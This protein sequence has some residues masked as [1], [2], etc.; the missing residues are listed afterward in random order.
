MSDS[1]DLTSDLL[2]VLA[3]GWLNHIS[4]LAGAAMTLQQHMERLTATDRD[5]LLRMVVRQ[6]TFLE[7]ALRDLLEQ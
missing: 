6:A 5:D 2:S 7:D 1:P 3:H 4:A